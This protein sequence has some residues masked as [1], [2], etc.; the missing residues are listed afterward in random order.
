[1]SNVVWMYKSDELQ[2]SETLIIVLFYPYQNCMELP[3]IM[4]SKRGKNFAFILIL[5]I[6]HVHARVYLPIV[7]TTHIYAKRT[8]RA[9]SEWN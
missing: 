2:F 7:C 1:M 8:R 6:G 4:F 9:Q 5:V 3:L